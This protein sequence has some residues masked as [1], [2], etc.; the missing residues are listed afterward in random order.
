VPP[1]HFENVKEASRPSSTQW[2]TTRFYLLFRHML[3]YCTTTDDLV[4]LS[5]AVSRFGVLH[6]HE[7]VKSRDLTSVAALS[8]YL[9]ITKPGLREACSR[10]LTQRIWLVSAASAAPATAA[11]A[12]TV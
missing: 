1:I 8:P 6:S 9:V 10:P 3:L 7:L 4:Y 12:G 11:T 2:G 5:S